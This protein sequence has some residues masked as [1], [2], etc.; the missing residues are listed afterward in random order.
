M[1]QKRSDHASSVRSD[2]CLQA[3]V[4][5]QAGGDA[6]DVVPHGFRRDPNASAM[7]PVD[8]PAAS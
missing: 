6:P 1:G 5:A 7:S 8:F 3:A 2:H 4:D